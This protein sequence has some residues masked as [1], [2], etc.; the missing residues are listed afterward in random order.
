VKQQRKS[1]SS[2]ALAIAA[3]FSC[4]LFISVF[5]WV[6]TTSQLRAAAAKGVFPSAEQGMISLINQGYVPPV[7]AK[8]VYA[9]T[10][11]F[12]GSS[13]HV[14]YVIACVRASQRS[15][16]STVGNGERDYDQPGSYFL[17]TRDGW[18]HMPEEAFPDFIGFWMK[19]YGLA[20][21]GST[22]PTHEWD[23]N[24]T[25]ECVH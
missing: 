20:G 21:E 5:S 24:A 8:I 16:G 1:F 10:N 13:P 23:S 17:Q 19:V 2:A 22:Q 7:D 14:W 25:G 9:G 4:L 6:Y 18:V 3:A 15:D 11:S 12:T